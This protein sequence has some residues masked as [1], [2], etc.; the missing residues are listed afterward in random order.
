MSEHDPDP[1]QA[2]TVV[3]MWPA[4]PR[5]RRGRAAGRLQGPATQPTEPLAG[6]QLGQGIFSTEWTEFAKQGSVFL[7]E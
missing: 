1:E 6:Q 7:N 3:C 2:A 4:Q 5:A